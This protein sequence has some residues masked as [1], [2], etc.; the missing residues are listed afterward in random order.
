MFFLF[1]KVEKLAG[2]Q[3]SLTEMN[4]SIEKLEKEVTTAKLENNSLRETLTSLKQQFKQ[5]QES[6]DAASADSASQQKW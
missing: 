5:Q 3:A 4:K 2:V 1:T 6:L